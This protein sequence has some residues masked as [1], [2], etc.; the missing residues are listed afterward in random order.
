MRNITL[1]ISAACLWAGAA[2]A[3][4]W[5]GAPLELDPIIVSGGLT[6]VPAEE[7]GRAVSVV[8][9]EDLARSQ[10]TY[11][12]DALRALPGVSVTRTGGAGGLT[13]VR[14]RGAEV[15]HTVV[16]I[17][18][19]EASAPENGEFD[20]GGL[21]TADIA[22]IEVL[23]GPQSAIYGSNAIGGVISITTREA[24]TAGTSHAASA[25]VGTDGTVGGLL[26]VR[27]LTDRANLSLSLAARD[28][29]GFDV[30]DTPGGEDDGD[31]NV[32]I[33][34]RA[35]FALTDALGVGG[36]LR[37]VDRTSAYDDF[38]F[39]A[40]SRDELVA[41]A[42]LERR[43]IE[44][45][46]SAFATLDALGGRMAN[47]LSLTH[48][49]MDDEDRRDGVRDADTTSR[50]TALRYLGTVALDAGTV[51]AATQT[52]SFGVERIEE[53]F[54]NN[55]AGLVFDPSQMDEQSR[56]LTGLIGQY[57][58]VFLDALSVQANLRHDFNDGFAD[59]TTWSLAGSWALP[60]DTTRLHASYGTGSQNP[61]LFEQFGYIPQSWVGNPDLKP[62]SS[63]GWDAGVEQGFLAGRAVIDV[64][65]FQDRLK[66]EINAT[67]DFATGES[68]PYNEDG[69]SERQGVEIAGT[70]QA[71]DA[72][73]LGLA[74][75][76]LDAQDPDGGQEVRRP[77]QE[78]ALNL[79]YA[80]PD[81][82][83]VLHLDA[84]RVIDNVDYDFTAPAFGTERVALDDYTLV[85]LA[86]EHRL[87]DTVTL[88]G[89]IE[90]LLDADYQELDGYAT[91]G[92]T[93]FLG[94]R[95]A[96]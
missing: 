24:E 26:A 6:P 96:F 8:T 3:Q 71:T 59:V 5:T 89:R 27:R 80:L 18:G 72:L 14:L 38:I 39:G 23:R 50:R 22:R 83:T 45:F 44:V 33:N 77:G 67:Y 95:S 94:L 13:Q 30:S 92:V 28:V 87:T 51:E 73:T 4:E 7:F 74:Y 20:F 93:A 42:D 61:T 10:A 43:R 65:Y 52:V 81:D 64:A 56:E 46:G 86:A 90:N 70:F 76:W 47:E 54:R 75:T 2:A 69:T 16:L 66:D 31:N 85:N 62:E 36:T 29:A 1:A 79:D 91:P 88:T 9:A 49:D 82:R 32:T 57:R 37:Y 25:E 21:L 17:D 15:N 41:D 68:T 58:G 84:R 55:D 12:A 53:S 19:V 48:A 34:A 78:I 35:S 63:R 11:V 40:P 60:N